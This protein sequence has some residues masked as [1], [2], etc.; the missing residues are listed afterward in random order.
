MEKMDSRRLEHASQTLE[1][2]RSALSSDPKMGLYWIK[3]ALSLRATTLTKL[4]S[5]EAEEAIEELVQEAAR[6]HVL[7]QIPIDSTQKNDLVILSLSL[8]NFDLARQ[9]ARIPS[10]VDE[11]PFTQLLEHLLAKSLGVIDGYHK[12]QG[13]VTSAEQYLIDDLT[14]IAEG[15]CT[16]LVSTEKFWSLTKKKRYANTIHEHRNFFKPALASLQGS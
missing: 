5:A 12:V 11:Y 3:S 1:K 13:K 9:L 10:T 7:L 15:K 6:L 2:G 8:R 16:N 4:E 14:A